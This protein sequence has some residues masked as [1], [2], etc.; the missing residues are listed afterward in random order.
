MNQAGIFSRPTH[1]SR[2]G[3][4]PLHHGPGIDIAARFKR[5]ELR[6]QLRLHA[7]NR[8]SSTL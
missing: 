3:Q 4:R 1:S 8:F 6:M 7:L 5:A 2:R